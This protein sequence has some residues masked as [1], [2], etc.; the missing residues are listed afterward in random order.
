MSDSQNASAPQVAGVT[1]RG[2]ACFAIQ[3]LLN[4]SMLSV[5]LVACVLWCVPS[6]L[7]LGVVASVEATLDHT[8]AKRARARLQQSPAVIH[9]TVATGSYAVPFEQLSCVSQIYGLGAPAA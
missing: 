7:L 1:V 3:L 9:N 6:S 2:V 4:V 5:T 8:R